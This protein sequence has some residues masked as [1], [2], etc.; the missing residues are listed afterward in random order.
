MQGSIEQ[1]TLLAGI[2]IANF[3]GIVAA[4]VSIKVALATLDVQMKQSQRDI[5]NLAKI[6]GT[7]R[8]RSENQKQE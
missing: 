3:G 6:I 8:S 7:N 2:L 4:Y 1:A 5:D